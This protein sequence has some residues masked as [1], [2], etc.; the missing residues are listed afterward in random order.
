[1]VRIDPDTV[2]ERDQTYQRIGWTQGTE[3]CMT[4]E[5]HPIGVVESPLVDPASAPKQGV[6]GSPEAWLAFDP[7]MADGIRDLAVGDEV[8]VLTWLHLADRSVLAVHPR[9]DPRTPDRCLQHPFLRRAQ[10]HRSAPS[11]D[12]RERRAPAAG[13]RPGDIEAG[14][15]FYRDLLGFVET[16]RTPSEGIPKH[17]EL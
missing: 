13:S 10:S 16:F 9:D 3:E 6:E 4:Y 12:A 17:V 2:V 11:S 5:I 8:F 14:L 15:R 7:A 1:L